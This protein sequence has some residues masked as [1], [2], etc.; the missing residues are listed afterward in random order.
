MKT[1][2]FPMIA[3]GLGL[4]LLLVVILGSKNDAD[5]TTALPLLTLLIVAEFAAVVNLIGAY[6]GYQTLRTDGFKWIPLA[7]TLLCALLAV[8]FALLGIDLWPL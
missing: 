3:V 2:R 7:N 5:G 8:E 1:A 6:I 4:P